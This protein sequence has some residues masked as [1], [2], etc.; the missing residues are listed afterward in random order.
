MEIRLPDKDIGQPKGFKDRGLNRTHSRTHGAG[1]EQSHWYK[2]DRRLPNQLQHPAA[3]PG[4][5]AV[6][7]SPPAPLPS[8]ATTPALPQLPGNRQ[9]S[10]Y[11]SSGIL[12]TAR[13]EWG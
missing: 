2:G 10:T 8:L 3:A 7:G 1:A 12:S 6:L 13:S 9:G 4:P 11:C 5:S